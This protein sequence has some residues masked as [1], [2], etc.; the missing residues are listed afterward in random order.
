MPPEE[1]CAITWT[2]QQSGFWRHFDLRGLPD[3]AWE[4]FANE[5]S[6]EDAQVFET[7]TAQRQY[8]EP[9]REKAV[10]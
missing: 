10:F 8:F 3:V 5:R 6:M 1:P 2:K 7:R 9:G 4:D